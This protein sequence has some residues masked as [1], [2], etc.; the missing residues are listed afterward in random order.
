MPEPTPDQVR[1]K[2]APW[3][4]GDSAGCR[5]NGLIEWRHVSC[6]TIYGAAKKNREPNGDINNWDA[7]TQRPQVVL[8]YIFGGYVG[9]IT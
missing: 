5:C 9:L 6:A 2:V 4:N 3:I 1:V 7:P 8:R